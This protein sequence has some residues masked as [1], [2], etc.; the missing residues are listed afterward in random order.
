LV[1]RVL[2][3]GVVVAHLMFVAFL[4]VGSL[5]AWRWRR[6]L[7]LHA[8]AVAWAAAIVIVGFR[9][10]LTTLEQGLRK[11]AGTS[12]YAGGFVDHYLAGVVYPGRFTVVARLAVAALIA[13]GYAGL[14]ARQR[15]VAAGAVVT[16]A[17][18]G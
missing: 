4:T 8:A 7:V 16:R 2:A 13:V 15:R 17:K 12:S 18:R 1:Y 10:P 5:L 14:L 9:C 3:D 11:R 6:L